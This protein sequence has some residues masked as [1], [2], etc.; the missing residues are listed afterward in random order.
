MELRI[1]MTPRLGLVPFFDVGSDYKSSYPDFS[2]LS[3]GAGIGLRYYSA[4]GPIRVDLATPI[5]PRPGDS[6][7]KVYV[8]L[9]QSF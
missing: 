3:E 5:D 9:G 4:I 7:I 1:R 2:T 6:R 8:G